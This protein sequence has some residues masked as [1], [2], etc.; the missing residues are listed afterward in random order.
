MSSSFSLN[1]DI[2]IIMLYC[3]FA[4]NP[5]FRYSNMH[6]PIFFPILGGGGGR[7]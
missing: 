4:M 2:I 5:G 1:K 6:L 3:S 7:G